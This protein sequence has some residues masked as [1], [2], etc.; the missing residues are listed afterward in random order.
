MSKLN[1]HLQIRKFLERA[2]K[3]TDEEWNVLSSRLVCSE[4]DKGDI[5]TA[6]GDI[7]NYMSFIVEGAIRVF[8]ETKD[9]EYT[10]EF[11]TPITPVSSYASFISRMPSMVNIEAITPCKLYRLSYEDMQYIYENTDAGEKV[12]RKM[13]EMAYVQREMKEIKLNTVSAECFYLDLMKDN[14]E[15]FKS[16]PQKYLASYLGIA[17]E[18]LSRIRNSISNGK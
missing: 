16:I 13:I 14:P 17:P 15:L 4:F 5:I 7:E 9:N 11:R 2:I 10:I 12:G 1:Y 3:T 18:S 8:Y 6:S